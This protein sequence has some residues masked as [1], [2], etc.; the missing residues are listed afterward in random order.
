MS[1]DSYSISKARDHL[2][3]L[4][5]EAEAGRTIELTR[6][7][8][9]VAVVLAI[10]EYRRLAAPRPGVWTAISRFR[11]RRSASDLGID[12]DDLLNGVREPSE[13]RDFDW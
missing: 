13:G 5:H 3:R 9:P 2:A 7:G 6:R 8:E 11:A 4:V 12:P 10:D 1:N